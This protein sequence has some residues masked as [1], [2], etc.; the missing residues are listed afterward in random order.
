MMTRV[1]VFI[2]YQ[3]MYHGARRAFADLKVLSPIF[4]HVH[5]VALG[6]LLTGL[7]RSADPNRKLVATTVYRSQPGRR[8]PRKLAV[9]TARQIARWHQ[10]PSFTVKTLPLRYQK[11]ETPGERWRAEEKGI[12][13]MLALDLV[14]GAH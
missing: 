11:P 3:N 7:G 13:V 12:D 9:T 14:L 5:P 8:S 1:A 2:D 6:R 4:G 10:H